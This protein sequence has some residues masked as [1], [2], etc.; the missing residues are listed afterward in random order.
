MLFVVCTVLRKPEPALENSS[1]RQRS[2]FSVT[3]DEMGHQNGM[4]FLTERQKW[5]EQYDKI[6]I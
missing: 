1:D 2:F 3:D 6:G 4:Q 5:S